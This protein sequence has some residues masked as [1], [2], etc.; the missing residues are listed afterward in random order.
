MIN[1]YNIVCSILFEGYFDI[2]KSKGVY[3]LYHA[4]PRRNY[5]SIMKKGLTPTTQKTGKS[6]LVWMADS[7]TNAYHHAKSQMKKKKIDDNIIIFKLYIDPREF[8]LYKA[9][10][11]GLYTTDKSI[12][13][14][15]FGKVI[16]KK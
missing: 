16:N 9:L 13:P 3:I 6:L 5:K 12:P 2:D 10:S 15:Y 8:T 11:K 7:M 14:K 1:L 4:T